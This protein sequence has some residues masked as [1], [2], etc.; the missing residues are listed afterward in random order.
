MLPSVSEH[1]IN[2]AP[3]ALLQLL[4]LQVGQG[5]AAARV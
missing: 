3:L 4:L 1:D 2:P 5:G